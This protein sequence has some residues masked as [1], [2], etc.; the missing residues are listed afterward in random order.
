MRRS[1]KP[2]VNSYLVF[3]NFDYK[4]DNG[5]WYRDERSLKKRAGAYSLY[6]TAL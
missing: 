2:A 4:C 6:A 5:E 3:Y 1:E